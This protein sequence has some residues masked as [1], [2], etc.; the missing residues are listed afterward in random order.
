MGGA[1][2]RGEI[3]MLKKVMSFAVVCSLTA[4][5]G[6][7]A[8]PTGPPPT[9][10][11]PKQYYLALGDSLAFG[12]QFAIFNQHFPTVPPELFRGYVDDFSQMLQGIR[13]D[14]ETMNL[15]CV[16]ETTDTFTHGGCLY[17]AQGF[18]L[19]NSYSGSQLDAAIAFLRA[20]RGKVSP[21]TFN[22]GTNDLNALT[23]LCG[24][25][26]LCYQPQGPMFLDRIAANIDRILGA[27]RAVAPDSEIIT[28]TGY[29]VAFLIDPRFLQITEAFNA[30]VRTTAVAHRVRVADVFG[31]FNGPPQPATI[32][33]LTS[34]CAS[35]DSHPTDSG[36]E[37]IAEQLWRVS[38][39]D[40]F[41]E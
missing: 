15:G 17:T 31:A 2:H 24:S 26:L 11:P 5:G 13:P 14:T 28:F 12:F 39:Y 19:H 35:G 3:S 25:D 21:I 18:Q 9:F 29:S 22:L 8:D 34:A 37:V 10:N 30:V 6:A 40:K 16:G 38:D 7:L 4:S 33:S 41:D 36:Y 27:L 1:A 20:H 32:C 23:A